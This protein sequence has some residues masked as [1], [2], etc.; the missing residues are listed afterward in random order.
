MFKNESVRKF[1]IVNSSIYL[2]DFFFEI[3][4]EYLSIKVNT[5][6]HKRH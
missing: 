2:S 1:L 6:V 3:S 5:P 4:L